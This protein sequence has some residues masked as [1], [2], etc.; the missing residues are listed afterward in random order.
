MRTSTS[1]FTL[2]KFTGKSSEIATNLEGLASVRLL[3]TETVSPEK[4]D[5]V[6]EEF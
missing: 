2:L 5:T 4:G 1:L 3:N 6:N